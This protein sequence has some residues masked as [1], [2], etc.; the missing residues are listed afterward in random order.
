MKKTKKRL[1]AEWNDRNV[2]YGTEKTNRQRYCLHAW[3]TFD[4]DGSGRMIT[5]CHDFARTDA[6]WTKLENKAKEYVDAG[7]TVSARKSG[8]EV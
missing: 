2:H 1:S 5:H 6:G 3:S 8:G 4:S 7:Y